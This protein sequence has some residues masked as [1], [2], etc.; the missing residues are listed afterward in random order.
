MANI[1]LAAGE[2]KLD[3][4]KEYVEQDGVSPNALDDNSYSPL[5]AAASWNHPDILSYL[6]ERGGDINL[7]DEDGETPLFVVETVGMARLVVQLGGNAQHRNS[8]GMTAAQQLQEE[9]PHISV[10]LRT[11]TG[12]STSTDDDAGAEGTGDPDLDA[13]TDE[14]MA[15]VRQIMEASQRGELTEAETDDKLRE[16]VEQ[17]VGDQIET[18]RA[19]G[20]GMEHEEGVES[21]DRP[22]DE[23]EPAAEA[24]R[25]RENIGR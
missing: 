12:E 5:H 20:A 9:H 22:E 4:V 11:L 2:G 25:P 16:V 17:I 19:I 15:A 21:R 6:V 8:D 23:S 18:G 14:L 13:P 3:K 7:V 24:K 1:W 10:Y